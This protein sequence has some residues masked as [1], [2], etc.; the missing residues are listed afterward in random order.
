MQVA[1]AAHRKAMDF[2]DAAFLARRKGNSVQAHEYY[3]QALAR[4]REA[5]NAIS[6]RYDL[7][8][9][10]SVLYRS[11]ATLALSCRDFREAERLAACGLVGENVPEEICEELHDVL[12]D[13]QRSRHHKLHGIIVPSDELQLSLE[14][15]A[16]GHGVIRDNLLGPR[17]QTVGIL[18][19]RTMS[20]LRRRPFE[21]ES[22]YHR[23][24]PDAFVYVSPP[25][26]ASH[27]IG[28]RIGTR[29]M[30]P[31]N[32]PLS[33][34]EESAPSR[35]LFTEVVDEFLTCIDLVNK[36]DMR[37]LR[38]RIRDKTYYRNFLAL[39]RSI[40]PDGSDICSVEFATTLEGEERRVV[41]SSQRD[42]LQCLEIMDSHRTT[43]ERIKIQGKLL[44]ASVIQQ[45]MGSI[46]VV[47]D[48]KTKHTI[49]VPRGLMA[50]V[51]GP[52]LEEEIV[53]TAANY[54]NR[55]VLIDIDYTNRDS[56]KV[57]FLEGSG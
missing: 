20:R 22:A 16:V 19:R 55:S 1:E 33:E 49:R 8:P 26:A 27:M 54:G 56:W 12:A 57:N 29:P 9:S 18:L 4:E 6:D 41:F 32:T 53:V 42:S 15:A 5:A 21:E 43:T 46:Q 7:E 48:S 52:M 50:D 3:R 24:R 25:V 13:V 31:M 40:A 35:N 23:Q 2:A 34:M 39:A 44:K 51:V 11:A 10:R 38:K 17:V 45:S 47:E 14:G 37:G 30:E 36:K 28:F